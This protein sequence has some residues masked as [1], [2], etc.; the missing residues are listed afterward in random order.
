[1]E[2]V[3]KTVHSKAFKVVNK[4]NAVKEVM[5]VTKGITITEEKPSTLLWNNKE[6]NLKESPRN[7][8]RTRRHK[9]SHIWKTFIPQKS[10]RE[11]SRCLSEKGPPKDTL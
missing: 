5:V 11:N 4:A 3:E 2:V 10:C 1:M 7:S 9:H 8:L 6:S